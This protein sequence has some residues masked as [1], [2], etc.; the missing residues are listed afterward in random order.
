MLHNGP[1]VITKR[2]FNMVTPK[3]IEDDNEK[4]ELEVNAERK[5]P[6]AILNAINPMR[7]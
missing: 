2:I 5:P 6:P 7:A 4:G 3:S 1:M